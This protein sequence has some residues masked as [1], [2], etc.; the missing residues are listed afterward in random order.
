MEPIPL[1]LASGEKE[2]MLLPQDECLVNTN[3]SPRH[4]WLKSDQQLLKKKGN[5]HG[6]HISNWI[7]ECLAL[8][9]EQIAAQAALPAEQHL[10]FTD[11]WKIIYPGKNHD[12][13][14][15]LDQLMEQTKHTV[16]I[17]EYLHPEKVAI[18]VF[19]CSSAHEGLII[20]ALNVN[21]MNI[22]PGGKQGI[23]VPQSFP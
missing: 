23:Y 6:I 3:D 19:D 12:A 16:D 2:H 21:N 10:K 8:N 13:W 4:Q 9:A 18:W 1:T 22:N 20:G 17:F 15:N 7:C 14:W 11:A 5:G